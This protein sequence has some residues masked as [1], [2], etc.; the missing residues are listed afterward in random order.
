MGFL[1]EGFFAR[2]HMLVMVWAVGRM[3]LNL[4]AAEH[5]SAGLVH[6]AALVSLD[7]GNMNPKERLS[8]NDL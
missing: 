8:G 7:V 3:L 5:Q 6:V 1:A 2:V 4:M